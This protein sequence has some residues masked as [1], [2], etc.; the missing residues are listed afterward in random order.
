M[1]FVRALP[2]LGRGDVGLAGGK[3]ANLGELV[4]AGFPVPDGLVLTTDAYRAFVDGAGIGPRILELAAGT[5]VD[6]AAARIRDLFRAAPVPAALS[7]ELHDAVA[8]L[9][10][11]PLAVRSSATAEDLE[12]ASFAGQQETTLD[13]RGPDAMLAA[14]RDCWASLWTARALDY[15]GRRGID[16]AGVA[17][18][19]VVQRMVDPDAAGVMFTA[20]PA[21]G[22][23]DETVVSAAWGL[24]ESVVGGEVSTDD[25][26]VS[27][28]GGDIRSRATADKA[29]MT[30]PT[31]QGTTQRP[32]PG[33]RRTEPVLDDAAVGELAGLGARIAAH[34]GAPQDVEWV[35]SGGEF[36]IVQS[37]PVTALPDPEPDPPSDW[38]VP[39]PRALYVRASIVEQLPDPLCTLFA[40]LVDGSVARTLQ[41]L[42]REILG[43]DVVR[44][45]DVGLPTVNGYAY[46]RYSRAAMGRMLLLTP[47]AVRVLSSSGRHSG[48]V[49]WRNARTPDTAVP[50]KR[51]RIGR[52]PRSPRPS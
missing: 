28:P 48:L 7:A 34:F 44:E 15:R 6:G 46:Y 38:S 32:V 45:G 18:A 17:L 24:G 30:V 43:R 39:D 13:V 5:D 9:G 25:V 4:R 50:S 14:V 47:F 22:R 36:R 8:L 16:P 49:R 1:T 26:V 20:N 11:G 51:G 3:G 2:T 40:D 10:E 12:G 52:F 42:V 37:R 31:G 35:R 21:T 27:M 23:R 19:V 29:V 41:A 33:D